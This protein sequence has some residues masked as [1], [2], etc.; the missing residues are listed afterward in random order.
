MSGTNDLLTRCL[1]KD[2]KAQEELYMLYKARVM[3]LCR[4]YT[5]NKGEAEDVY[6]ETFV[7]VFRSLTQLHDPSHLE[8]WIKKIAVN[9]AVN[10]YHRSKRHDHTP[11]RNGHHYP[12][13]AHMEILSRLSDEML[14]GLI[15]QLPDGYRM[16][17]NLH[18]I[19]GYSHPEIGALLN[20]SETT[21]RSQL[22]RA[23]Q[24]LRNKLKRFGILKYE[25]YE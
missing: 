3:G 8:S 7:R 21:S 17:F 25:S 23:K 20:I 15:N 6:Q 22:N 16:V 4:R 9:T 11:E 10:Y 14:V 19:E 1:R 2:P 13:G 5:R 12:S 24:A 18:E